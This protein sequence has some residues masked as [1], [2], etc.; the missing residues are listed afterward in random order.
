MGFI[1]VICWLVWAVSLGIVFWGTYKAHKHFTIDSS[2]DEFQTTS[3]IPNFQNIPIF[4]PVSILKPIKGHE[5]GLEKNLETFFNLQYPKFEL[6]FSIADWHDPAVNIVTNLIEKHPEVNARLIIG[7][8]TVGPNPKVNNLLRGYESSQ[9]D[10]IL[11]SDSNVTV[12][13]SYLKSKVKCLT[14]DVGVVTGVVVGHE[15]QTFGGHLEAMF[16]NTFY[17]RW[18]LIAPYFGQDCVVGKSML[19]RKTTAE[20]FGGILQLGRYLAEDYMTGEAMRMLG[21]KVAIMHQPIRQPLGRYSFKE[22]WHRHIRWGRIRKA[23][24]PLPVFFE[25]W[26]GQI[27]SGILGSYACSSWF[28]VN[29][30]LFFMAHCLIWFACDMTT[31]LILGERLKAR[32]PL[33]WALREALAIPLWIQML[34]GNSVMWRGTKY[35]VKSGGL[36]ES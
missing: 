18:M 17:A 19:F 32:N 30:Y 20:R 14:A 21:L 1:I 7:A 23:Q 12:P 3:L 8:V 13:P 34:A 15:P 6:I 10:L 31:I 35:R 36:L 24:A 33:I 27:P 28:N 25:P 26:L 16:L 22:F 9:Y 29:F 11:I 4:Q 2:K 5:P